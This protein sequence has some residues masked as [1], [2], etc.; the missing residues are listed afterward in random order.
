MPLR[1]LR[2]RLLMQMMQV[3]Q[4]TAVQTRMMEAR[5]I[6]PIMHPPTKW[7]GNQPKGERLA[8]ATAGI[9]FPARIRRQ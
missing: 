1:S 9:R 5:P 7:P 6:M 4:V 2:T 8:A 3:M